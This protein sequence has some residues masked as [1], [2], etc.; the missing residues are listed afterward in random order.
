MNYFAQYE[1]PGEFYHY[2]GR[3]DPRELSEE[4]INLRDSRGVQYRIQ[5]LE[6]VNEN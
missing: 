4:D 3:C 1:N 2:D 5:Y 6:E